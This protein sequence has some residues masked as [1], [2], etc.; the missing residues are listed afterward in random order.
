MVE[1]PLPYQWSKLYDEKK[2]KNSDSDSIFFF[3]KKKKSKILDLFCIQ[4]QAR[5][6]STDMGTKW[7][8][9]C[10]DR[11]QCFAYFYIRRRKESCIPT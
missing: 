5:S 4:V 2:K 3:Q 6:K 8:C 7:A 9:L 11:I 1:V 10:N